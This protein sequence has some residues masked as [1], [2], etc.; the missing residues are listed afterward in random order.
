MIENEPNKF[1]KPDY[2]IDD[3]RFKNKKHYMFFENGLSDIDT[4][5]RGE[6][7]HFCEK[8]RNMGGKVWILNHIEKLHHIGK[9]TY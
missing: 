5:Y 6:D 3:F 1:Y 8:W 4:I 9:Y 7:F 2:P